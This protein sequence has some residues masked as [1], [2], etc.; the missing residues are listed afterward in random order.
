MHVL[1]FAALLAWSWRKWP[2]PLVDFGRELYVPWQLTHGLVLY[3]DLAS[4]FGPVSPY[5]NALWFRLFGASLMTL[6]FCNLVILSAM[7]AGIHYLVRV[8]TDR[9]T[10]SAAS[11]TTLLLF[12]FSQ[13]V[14]VGN[15]N[16]VTPYSHEATH[17]L[18]LSVASLVLLYHALANRSR[19]ACAAAGLCFGLVLLTKP[20]IAAA[21]VAGVLA[22]WSAA[23]ALGSRDRRDLAATVPLFIAAAAVPSLLFFLYFMTQMETAAA[24]RATLG[25]WVPLFGTRIA[26]N[27]FYRRIMGFEAPATSAALMLLTF[28]GFTALAGAA[29][30]VSVASTNVSPVSRASRLWRI[31]FLAIAIV[32]LRHG[33]F[34]RA[35]PLIVV[36]ALVAEIVLF[37]RVRSDRERALRLISLI[38]WSAFGLVLLAKMGLNTRLVQYG[39][40]LALPAMVVAITLTS[41]LIPQVLASWKS[42]AVARGFRQIA[43][44]TLAAAIAPYLGLAHGW[45]RTKTIAIGA[46]ADRFYASSMSGQWQG[47][48]VQDALRALKESAHPGAILAVLPEGV[49]INYLLR[50]DSPLRIVNPMPPELMA[51]GEDDVLRSLMAK[52][53]DF[54]LLIEKDTSEYGYPPFGSDPRYGLTTLAWIHQ[55]YETVRVI[56]K[57]PG[58]ESEAV[59]RLMSRRKE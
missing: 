23:Y 3:R 30:A 39:F 28:A 37:V 31:G 51:F 43:L 58:R 53:P 14:D 1:L 27:E 13:Y 55:R 18:A 57:D 42:E 4:L 5:V 59:M 40:Y 38:M 45:Y 52:P 34:P 22:G 25:A 24:L 2:D 17:G 19:R 44:W 46:G 8:S 16:F 7:V 50:L 29:V 12:G 33:T 6:V 36:T 56:R 47:A 10:A 35:L 26:T 54:V 48:A 9:V 20:E 32:L 11:L 21:A 49:M 15:Y 41:S